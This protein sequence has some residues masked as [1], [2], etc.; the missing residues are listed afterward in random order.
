MHI[1]EPNMYTSMN[2]ALVDVHC[3]RAALLNA[4]FSMQT[5]CC[6]VMAVQLAFDTKLDSCVWHGRS[7]QGQTR[8]S[9]MVTDQQDM[10]GLRHELVGLAKDLDKVVCEGLCSCAQQSKPRYAQGQ[11]VKPSQAGN[12]LRELWQHEAAQLSSTACS[13]QTT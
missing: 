3:G 1:H 7:L 8:L 13:A 11:Q 9:S 2:E 5:M 6:Q 10:G 12:M 4:F